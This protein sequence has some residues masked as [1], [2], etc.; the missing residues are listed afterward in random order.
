MVG[1]FVH[2]VELS[3]LAEAN[4]SEVRWWMNKSGMIFGK[5]SI[6]SSVEAIE[7]KEKYFSW[8]PTSLEIRKDFEK[9]SY[10]LYPLTLEDNRG[11]C[12]L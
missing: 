12:S 10:S 9:M 2:L 5:G 6:K 11:R 7:W 1:E 8:K 4:E 3:L